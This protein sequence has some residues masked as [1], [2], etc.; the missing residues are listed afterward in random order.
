MLKYSKPL[1]DSWITMNKLN[2]TFVRAQ[3]KAGRELVDKLNA[4]NGMVP[5]AA[6]ANNPEIIRLLLQDAGAKPGSMISFLSK[7]INLQLP[8]E[9][10][11]NITAIRLCGLAQRAGRKGYAPPTPKEL[12][13]L[14]GVPLFC[15]TSVSN[16]FHQCSNQKYGY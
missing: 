16:P 6:P 15:P 7:G 12:A 11:A 1:P 14:I 9:K 13:E 3:E 10:D 2:S 4:L 5:N 8:F